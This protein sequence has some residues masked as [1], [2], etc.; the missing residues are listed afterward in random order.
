MANRYG[1]QYGLTLEK[2]VVNLFAKV[3]FGA[4]GAPTLDAKNSK[5][6]VSV[7]RNSTGDFTFVFGTK[8][9]MLD[10][11]VKLLGA[12]P[13]FSTASTPASPIMSVKTISISSPGTC[14]IELVFANG[15]GTLTDPANGEVLYLEFVFGDS[16]AP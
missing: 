3:S 1:Y 15:S 11:Y 10:T 14:S 6:V 5:G 4:A 12:N 2:K 9:G 16:T 7:T 13:L 8:A